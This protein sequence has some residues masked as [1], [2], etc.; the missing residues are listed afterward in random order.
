MVSRFYIELLDGLRGNLVLFGS[1][2]L[3]DSF[4]KDIAG[5][6][7]NGCNIVYLLPLMYQKNPSGQTAQ[8]AGF[9]TT[10]GRLA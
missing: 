5:I 2:L 6:N 9:S 4:E 1:P 7:E 10:G 3:S 8:L